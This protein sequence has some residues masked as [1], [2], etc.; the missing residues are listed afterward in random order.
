LTLGTGWVC[1]TVQRYPKWAAQMTLSLITPS[2]R[3]AQL[4]ATLTTRP[5]VAETAVRKKGLGAL[6]VCVDERMFAALSSDEQ[7]VVR[8]PR[9][10]VE[11]LIAYGRGAR[12][13]PGHGQ[14]MQEWFVAAPG[15]EVDWLSLAEE[16]LSFVRGKEIDPPGDALP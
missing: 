7:L 15:T 6:A 5:G 1:N 12:F 14:P 10:R 13:V 2:H 4:V 8:L 11:E 3:Y 16:A 9:Q